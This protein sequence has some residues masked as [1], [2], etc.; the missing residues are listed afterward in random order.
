M[1]GTEKGLYLC[2]YNGKGNKAQ[3]VLNLPGNI[4]RVEKSENLQLLFLLQ[5]KFIIFSLFF[6][7]YTIIII[8]LDQELITYPY[9]ALEATPIIQNHIHF[10][11][12]LEEEMKTDLF[13]SFDEGQAQRKIFACSGKQLIK[14]DQNQSKSEKITIVN[15][16]SLSFQ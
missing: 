14:I 13:C 10:E 6:T 15:F 9:L 2:E 4:T 8:L 7:K 16:L 5:S 3:K 1:L 11:D 12:C